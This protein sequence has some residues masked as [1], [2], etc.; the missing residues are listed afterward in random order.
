MRSQSP[1]AIRS[2][3]SSSLPI[4]CRRVTWPHGPSC[5][6]G[7]ETLVKTDKIRPPP[8]VQH[9]AGFR[10]WGALHVPAARPPRFVSHSGQLAN[11]ESERPYMEPSLW[12]GSEDSTYLP[13]DQRAPSTGISHVRKL[14]RVPRVS[15]RTSGPSRASLAVPWRKM[16]E[17]STLRC[18]PRAPSHLTLAAGARKCRTSISESVLSRRFTKRETRTPNKH[19]KRCSTSLVIRENG[20]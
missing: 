17:T 5:P 2:G 3:S 8:R 13:C 14:L 11:T 9:Q 16:M 6:R 19:M 10:F 7:C 4:Q 12:C 18:L 15:Y 20:H 1:A